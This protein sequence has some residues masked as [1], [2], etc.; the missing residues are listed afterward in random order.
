MANRKKHLEFLQLASTLDFAD[1]GKSDFRMFEDK[2]KTS[3]SD[4]D[5]LLHTLATASSTAFDNYKGDDLLRWLLHREDGCSLLHVKTKSG[6]KTTPIHAAI[7]SKNHGFLESVLSI[8]EESIR[9]KSDLHI[10][11]VTALRTRNQIIGTYTC[12]HASIMEKLPC[13]ERMV[14]LCAQVEGQVDGRD[15]GPAENR[16]VKIIQTRGITEQW[17]GPKHDQKIEPIFLMRDIL[18]NTALHLL[19]ETKSKSWPAREKRYAAGDA[20]T[21][22][23]AR[24][25]VVRNSDEFVP[26]R[27][28]ETLEKSLGPSMGELWTAINDDGLSPFKKRL[29]GV[30]TEDDDA[31]FQRKLRKKILNSLTEIPKLKRA[32][33]GTKEKE[34]CLDMSDFNQSSHDFKI[35][36]DELK[37]STDKGL[38]FEECLLSVFLPDLNT[39]RKATPHDGVRDLFEWLRNEG[40]VK[41]IKSLNIPDSTTLP[42]SDELVS[43]AIIDVFEVEKFDWRK[44]DINLDILVRSKHRDEFTNLTLYSTGNYSVMHH[45]ISPEGLEK[46]TSLR[47]VTIEIMALDELHSEAHESML[48]ILCEKQPEQAQT[49]HALLVDEY[50]KKLTT[51]LEAMRE[52]K[53]KQNPPIDFTY[54]INTNAKWDFPVLQYPTKPLEEKL[55]LLTKLETCRKFL[56]DMKKRSEYER[57]EA[58]FQLL[59]HKPGEM[60]RSRLIKVAIIDNGA[61]KFRKKIRDVIE[62]GVS[63]V[64]ADYESADRILPWWMVSD[65]HGTQMAYLIANANPWCRLYIARVG[66]SRRDILPEDAVQAVRWAIDQGVDIISISWITKSEF[67]ELKQAIEDAT[68]HALVF[69]STADEG[70][71]ANRV[72]PACYP[73]TVRVSATDKYGNLMPTSDKDAINIPV[74]GQDIPA[75]G[76]SYMGAGI[77]WG[78]VSGSSVATALAAGIASLALLLLQVFNDVNRDKLEHEGFY[79]NEKIVRVLSRITDSEKYPSLF[80]T[81]ATDQ[82]EL[83]KRWNISEFT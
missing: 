74:P 37:H 53:K 38:L 12:L 54:I 49:R 1:P 79:K 80:P 30:E 11:I 18:N 34:L 7:S 61:D 73:G 42:M 17:I 40:N 62:K 29:D 77:A 26:L 50:A 56:G 52:K 78:T 2:F 66:K 10:E 41:R 23:A 64:K 55:E 36:V 22:N 72:Y 8:A 9:E 65:A 82:D 60:D 25:K 5:E 32:L 33:Y 47:K 19:M 67:P 76:P 15:E 4:Y 13:V 69:C 31:D 68:K 59:K 70:S 45:W 3:R 21:S 14:E 44:L 58:R 63:Y 6:N 16:L 20:G 71:W 83:P 46:L 39:F 75:F 35:F 24:S 57:F 43:E 51:R 81:R 48:T 28:I 27:V